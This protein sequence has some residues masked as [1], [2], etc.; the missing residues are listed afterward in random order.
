[1]GLTAQV[2]QPIE[3]LRVCGYMAQALSALAQALEEAPQ[4]PICELDVMPDEE[5]AL[6]LC[7]WNHTTEPYPAD[8]CV[9]ELFE[10]QA[11]LTP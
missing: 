7:S 11:Q 3:A 1:L 10:Q 4:T 8:T 6:Q 5:Y 2:R 9:H